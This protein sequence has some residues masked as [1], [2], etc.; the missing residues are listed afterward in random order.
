LTRTTVFQLDVMFGDCDPAGIVFFPNFSR[1]MDAASLHF[2]LHL[3]PGAGPGAPHGRHLQSRG[4]EPGARIAM[5]SKNCAH[6]FMAELAIWMAGYTTV[7]IFPTET[8]ETVQLRAGA[9]RRQPAV[10]RQAR[11]LGRS[12]S[13]ACRRPALHRASRWR[14]APTPFEGWDERSSRA[15]A[16]AGPPRA[17]AGRAGDDHLHLGLHRHSPRA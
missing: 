8:A 3:G 9:Q 1:W 4:F 17:R 5:L 12:S 11:H 15:P 7:A 2:R 6:F 14:R 13:P 16:A 10:R